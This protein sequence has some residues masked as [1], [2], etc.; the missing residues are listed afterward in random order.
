MGNIRS[1]I[2]NQWLNYA[3]G[4]LFDWLKGMDT[5][6]DWLVRRGWGLRSA[7][8]PDMGKP[9]ISIIIPER[10]NPALLRRCLERLRNAIA[11]LQEPS[12]VIVVVNGSAKEDYRSLV[13][14]Y[15]QV[16][17]FFFHRPLWFSGAVEK[18]LSIARFDWVYLL[19]NDM[20]LEP[21]TLVEIL[22]WRGPSVF[23]VASQI[24]F[25]DP[26]KRR[27]ETGWTQYGMIN[28][29][30]EVFDALPEEEPTVRGTLY[31]GGGASLFQK[32]LL[33]KLQR[34]TRCYLPC[35]WEDVEWGVTAWRLGYQVLFCP[36]SRAW[37]HHRATH[38]KVFSPQELDA[39][40]RRNFFMLLLRTRLG[41][42]GSA[43]LEYLLAELN[44]KEQRQLMT[45]DLL[46]LLF[47]RLLS[48]LWPHADF[49]LFCS[50][51]KRYFIPFRESARK[52]A[53]I[54]VTPYCIYPPAHGGA[55]RLCHLIR[56]LSASY[57][58][59]LLSD[60][61]ILYTGKSTRYYASLASLHVA[62]RVEAPSPEPVRIRRI[63]SH[64]H[65]ALQEQ[66]SHMITASAP[67]G[68]QIE[69]VELS[70]LIQARKKRKQPWILTLHDVLLSAS[71]EHYSAADRY[72][73]HWIQQY[74]AVVT[75]VEE[76]AKL[77]P[78]HIV[79]VVPNATVA[80]PERYVSS[81][82]AHG[83]LFMGPFRYRPNMEGIKL[84]LER[85]F[86]RL[87]KDFSNLELW[88]LGGSEA[89]DLTAD[90]P[91]FQ[92]KGVFVHGFTEDP[93]SF[94][95]RCALT[96]NPLFGVHGTS[97]KV[98]ESLAAGRI[99]IS[100]PDGAR[101]FNSADFP[102]LQVAQDIDA[103]VPMIAEFLR[104]PARRIALEKPDESVLHSHS[105]GH[106]ADVLKMLYQKLSMRQGD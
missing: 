93:R 9:G 1:R 3:I 47:A 65:P 26:E 88:I 71:P 36:A 22:D 46:G 57:Q 70:Q 100:S 75:V 80:E 101:G 31:A 28:E 68:V 91:L 86:P 95:D 89:L 78:A 2:L 64:S 66:L 97:L 104:N 10:D 42:P 38:G 84:F 44:A 102:A 41:E 30:L 34:R 99:C 59:H 37:H 49:P 83:L 81:E 12:E 76:E 23:A 90:S 18:G 72:E 13:A 69:F 32:R 39:I 61:E 55:V 7:I 29:R 82:G 103:F 33:Q 98:I 74:D 20:L 43:Q 52:P 8:Q 14:D 4:H 94:L 56:E 54:V 5:L 19:N 87:R 50:W 92:Q 35:Y 67:A 51:R 27:E 60:E 77:V 96:V 25:L 16:R 6:G 40:F 106:S 48:H 58:V 45:R 73:W 21:R 17:W 79:S 105:W 11:V 63:K 53:L 85:V 24:F 15:P 62:E